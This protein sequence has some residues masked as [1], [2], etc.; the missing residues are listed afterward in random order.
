LAKLCQRRLT[1]G[2]LDQSL[3][4]LV[5]NFR[6][7][8]I[9]KAHAPRLGLSQRR[10]GPPRDQ[11]SLLFGQHCDLLPI[12]KPITSP[13]RERN[14][15]AESLFDFFLP[16]RLRWCALR[17]LLSKDE[18]GQPPVD[19]ADVCVDS[20]RALGSAGQLAARLDRCE[21]QLGATPAVGG[22]VSLTS[23]SHPLSPKALPKTRA[24]SSSRVRTVE[25]LRLRGSE[26]TLSPSS[27]PSLSANRRKPEFR[28]SAISQTFSFLGSN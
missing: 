5:S 12:N 10:H 27:E 13:M 9:A 1:L 19:H 21:G 7:V 24:L 8:R 14:Q 23:A 28:N 3:I 15:V 20:S 18:A 4:H 2:G 11:R 22:A 17:R 26:K 16:A 6:E 25:I